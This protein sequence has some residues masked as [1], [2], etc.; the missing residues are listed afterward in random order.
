MARARQ[1]EIARPGK[2]ILLRLSREV[3]VNFKTGL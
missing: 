1:K 3:A 2:E